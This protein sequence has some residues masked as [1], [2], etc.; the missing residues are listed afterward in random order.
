MGGDFCDGVIIVVLPLNEA[1]YWRSS[2]V[3]HEFHVKLMCVIFV[4]LFVV[5]LSSLLIHLSVLPHSFHPYLAS[6]S[7]TGRHKP[8]HF[9]VRSETPELAKS[10]YFSSNK[11]LPP[12]VSPTSSFFLLRFLLLLSMLCFTV[13]VCTIPFSTMFR[14]LDLFPHL[15]QTPVYGL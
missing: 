6:Q 9:Y 12:Q 7:D 10:S 5:C 13:N 2:W 1:K 14:I 15:T 3:L 11:S 4:P 8:P